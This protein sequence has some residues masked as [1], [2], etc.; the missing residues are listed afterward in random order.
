[1][2]PRRQAWRRER[3]FRFVFRYLPFLWAASSVVSPLP[4]AVPFEPLAESTLQFL[5]HL[6][7]CPHPSPLETWLA[8]VRSSVFWVAAPRTL[9]WAQTNVYWAVL[10]VTCWSPF[11]GLLLQFLPFLLQPG[12]ST[13][14][15]ELLPPWYFSVLLFYSLSCLLKFLY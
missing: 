15:L 13:Y 4:V 11:Q 8:N 6:Q 14:F 2:R 12:G 10:P 7:N 9:L 3:D 5:Q 1:M